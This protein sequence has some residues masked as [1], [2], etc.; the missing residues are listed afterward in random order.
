MQMP[1]NANG[2]VDSFVDVS[3]TF[4]KSLPPVNNIIIISH[5]SS[6]QMCRSEVYDV[7]TLDLDFNAFGKKKKSI[8]FHIC[9]VFRYGEPENLN[10]FFADSDRTVA[11]PS[12]V[13]GHCSVMS[14]NVT[15]KMYMWLKEIQ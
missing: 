11:A 15:V 1:V 4:C 7:V 14:Q 10:L 3:R 5:N 6:A 8:A 12:I 9:G 2:I 13:L